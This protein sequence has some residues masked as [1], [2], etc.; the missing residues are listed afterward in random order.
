MKKRYKNKHE[1]SRK[2]KYFSTLNI[3][4]HIVKIDEIHKFEDILQSYYDKHKKK[5]INFTVRVV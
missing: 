1:Q 3:K 5:F 2:H 4:K